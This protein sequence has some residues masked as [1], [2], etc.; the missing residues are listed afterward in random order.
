M[1][2]FRD[3]F[4]EVA[5]RRFALALALALAAG[6]AGCG[7]IHG[8]T[9]VGILAASDGGGG[10]SQNGDP[11]I[12]SVEI[13][14]EPG[15]PPGPRAGEIRVEVTISDPED[16]PAVLEML[17]AV[18]GGGAEPA[19]HA[20][21]STGPQRLATESGGVSGAAYELVW[22]SATD[23]A[24]LG[25]NALAV[26][27]FFAIRKPGAARPSAVLSTD[28]FA[29]ENDPPEIVS[30]ALA[31]GEMGL[32]YSEGIGRGVQVAG[33]IPPYT[34]EIDGPALASV[35][36]AVSSD[37]ASIAGT[38]T[39]TAAG[40]AF[41]VR[42]VDAAGA[43][44]SPV[45]AAL[46]IRRRLALATDFLPLALPGEPY[47]YAIP[48]VGGVGA[49]TFEIVTGT[50]TPRF[51]PDPRVDG[52]ELDGGTLRAAAAPLADREY[53][54][55]V[56]VTDAH[57]P[58]AEDLR[59]YILRVRQFFAVAENFALP[60]R[61]YAALALGRLAGNDEAGDVAI[62]RSALGGG[63]ILEV[64]ENVPS[65]ASGGGTPRY[66]VALSTL[67]GSPP[68]VM[69]AA[70][71]EE[72]AIAD[73]LIL[74]GEGFLEARVAPSF[75]TARL[76]HPVAGTVRALAAA[77]LFK[78]SPVTPAVQEVIAAVDAADGSGASLVV[79]SA[80]TIATAATLS[81]QT[82]NDLAALAVDLGEG[83]VPAV[84]LVAHGPLGGEIQ[85]LRWDGGSGTFVAHASIGPLTTRV[86]VVPGGTTVTATLDPRRVAAV[87]PPGGETLL[88]GG[89]LD[90]TGG[91]AAFELEPVTFSIRRV[92]FSRVPG[93]SG[94]PAAADF[95]GDGLLDLVLPLPAE[96]STVVLLGTD[97]PF[98]PRVDLAT[99][100]R[101]PGALRFPI[102]TQPDLV[103]VGQHDGDPD[104]LFDVLVARGEGTAV[105]AAQSFTLV[106]NITGA[107]AGAGPAPARF[108]EIRAVPLEPGSPEDPEDSLVPPA[109]LVG[110]FDGDGRADVAVQRVEI[111]P[112]PSHG[113]AAIDQSLTLLEGPDADDF[114][115][116]DAV[117]A[118]PAP[119]ENSAT[120]VAFSGNGG[121]NNLVKRRS[122]GDVSPALPVRVRLGFAAGDIDGAPGGAAEVA[123][124][125]L[126]GAIEVRGAVAG[127]LEVRGT[128][129][130]PLEEWVANRIVLAEMHAIPTGTSRNADIVALSERHGL[131]IFPQVAPPDDAPVTIAFGA[132]FGPYLGDGTVNLEV[133]VADFDQ[134]GARDVAVAQ[135]TLPPRVVPLYGLGNGDVAPGEPIELALFGPETAIA[136]MDAADVDGDGDVDIAFLVAQRIF[137]ETGAPAKVSFV[138]LLRNEGGRAFV[139]PLVNVVLAGFH[140]RGL[141]VRD[142]TG[143][144]IV[145]VGALGSGEAARLT[146]LRGTGGAFVETSSLLLGRRPS[147]LQVADLDRDGVPD[148]AVFCDA[149]D[150]VMIITSDG[151]GAL[152][153]QRAPP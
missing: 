121:G 152:V 10:G 128:V 117:A 16:D 43:R 103:L 68:V 105:A 22:D 77:H 83:P 85:I 56:R 27:L 135:A 100:L 46:A 58:P 94:R 17:F 110:D 122:G 63:P 12:E 23:L 1:R 87:G 66:E 149:Y 98:D 13:V 62:A 140:D 18:N 25:G 29:V 24:P 108:N 4:G 34:L 30:V 92:G 133:V 148:F 72:G 11:V 107:G 33:G 143:D 96:R 76:A 50:A 57:D 146:L 75:D 144:G 115:D 41:D 32:A 136:G 20:D 21:G 138:H 39:A 89:T 84:A 28:V 37:G 8:A 2:R 49:L 47:E 124:G 53:R 90:V 88:V 104:G 91:P 69:A 137:D 106:R 71:L 109:L 73:D 7:L 52:F 42:V 147:A 150:E 111:T 54:F 99:D 5:G 59:E 64:L 79:A 78:E 45:T 80:P 19:T 55:A 51:A 67:L 120:E 48:T 70:R 118:P 97:A 113:V 81:G 112:T 101:S 14:D 61:T 151:R 26:Q 31:E 95:N 93:F 126:D 153:K 86:E 114:D 36:L 139:D 134:D 6:G 3:G 141:A 130:P 82:V 15:A 145:D 116:E 129:P 127:V 119:V 60:G 102:Q 123:L 65:P 74:G 132:A 44:T 131:A 142:F 38:P 9:V 125:T 35:G 40:L